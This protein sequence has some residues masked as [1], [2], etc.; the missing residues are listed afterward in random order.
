ML[1]METPLIVRVKVPLCYTCLSR[2]QGILPT[3]IIV[4]VHFDLITQPARPELRQADPILLHRSIHVTTDSSNS[5]YP[6]L[7]NDGTPS[8]SP[9]KHNSNLYSMI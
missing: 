7:P 9:P 2:P 5:G 3:L 1:N 8:Q 4:L 6:I